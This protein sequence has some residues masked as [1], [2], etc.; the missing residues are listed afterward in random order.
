MNLLPV[1]LHSHQAKLFADNFTG[2]TVAAIGTL[3]YYSTIDG[4]LWQAARR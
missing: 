3:R 2:S 4:L 1:L